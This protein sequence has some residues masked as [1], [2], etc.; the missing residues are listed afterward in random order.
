MKRLKTAGIVA[1]AV[2]VSPL[3]M[4][5]ADKDSKPPKDEEFYI[6]HVA[7]GER[8]NSSE[9][10]DLIP[11]PR[12]SEPGASPYLINDPA[13]WTACFGP[14]FNANYPLRYPTT[15]QDCSRQAA[16]AF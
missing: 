13:A 7:S 12:S 10:Q 1:L 3:L 2:L 8:I 4:G 15:S 6:L 14:T 9:I 16:W 11:E 5:A